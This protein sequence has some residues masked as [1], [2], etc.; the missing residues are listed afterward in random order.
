MKLPA[1]SGWGILKIL[2]N[3]PVASRGELS[4]KDQVELYKV[5][6]RYDHE[7]FIHPNT[8]LVPDLHNTVVERT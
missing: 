6:R 5:F 8:K 3:F 7:K 4:F 1:A 2:I